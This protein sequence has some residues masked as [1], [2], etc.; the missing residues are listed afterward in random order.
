MR[1]ARYECG[2]SAALIA[3]LLN[4]P[5]WQVRAFAIR[6]AAR[7]KLTPPAGFLST[8]IEPRVFRAALRHGL[9]VDGERVARGVRA[10]A[11]S[12]E[13]RDKMLAAELG[14][15]SGNDE[16]VELATT[17]CKQVILKMGRAEAGSL[18]SRLAI[19][20]GQS[21]LH[22]PTEWQQWLM[23]QGRRFATQSGH[24]KLSEGTSSSALAGIDSEPFIGLEN[25]IQQL[26]SR[27]LDLAICLDCTASMYGELA[28]AQGGIDDLM[29]FC[30]DVTASTRIAI[31]AYRD[32]REEFETK[33]WDFTGDLEQART[34]LWTLNAEG[35]GD[36]P[37]S[38]R[39]ALNLAFTQL[40][41]KPEATKVLVLVGDAPPHVGD[42]GGC[43]K[44]AA[45]ARTDAAL[46]THV[47][48]VEGKS[49]KHFPEIA[50]AG[51]GKCV[52]LEDDDRLIGEIAGLSL[53]DRYEDEFAEFFR[54]YLEL[55][56]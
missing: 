37:E 17:L 27:Q 18:S 44:M 23:K 51:G 9:A 56:R 48:Q 47:I 38:V 28:A 36:T 24:S 33:A 41:W 5:A 54:V 4:D 45:L 1:L 14:A 30:A 19:L 26:A 7:R 52:T 2:D 10:L 29:R 53:A 15:A 22:R 25:Y 34:Q 42:G 31:V 35:G 55:C 32:R 6:E 16:L 46:I 13:L 12:R 43:I 11:K 49:V 50:E 40:S 39:A 3:T 20:T 8:E 21:G